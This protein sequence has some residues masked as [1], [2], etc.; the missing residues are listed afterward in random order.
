MALIDNRADDTQKLIENSALTA[1]FIDAHYSTSK[2]YAM[3]HAR[4]KIRELIAAIQFAKSEPEYLPAQY[5]PDTGY[6]GPTEHSEPHSRVLRLAFE[7]SKDLAA[8]YI[9]APYGWNDPNYCSEDLD[10]ML[11]HLPQLTDLPA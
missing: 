1:D 9:L 10:T 4:Y 3:A 8:R 11:S 7:I 6:F 5:D 2:D